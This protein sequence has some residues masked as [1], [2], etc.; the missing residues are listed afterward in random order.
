MSAGY[1]PLL[2][3]TIEVDLDDLTVQADNSFR[4]W[5]RFE[6]GAYMALD[7]PPESEG[8]Q[9]IV[10]AFTDVVSVRLGRLGEHGVLITGLTA[11][12]SEDQ[13]EESDS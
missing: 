2:P 6:S 5:L 7:I 12:D 11:V 8:H 3:A 10:D 13:P 4:I 9:Q 1:E